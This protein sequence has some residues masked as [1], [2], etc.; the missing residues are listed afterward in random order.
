MVVQVD[1]EWS[2]VSYSLQRQ[3]Y[4]RY[5][6]EVLFIFVYWFLL[7]KQVLYSQTKENPYKQKYLLR[8]LSEMNNVTNM[9]CSQSIL[10]MIRYL[11]LYCK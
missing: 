6:H 4:F 10:Y 11:Y 2:S 1:I 9:Y 3:M 7:Y 8:T 5:L